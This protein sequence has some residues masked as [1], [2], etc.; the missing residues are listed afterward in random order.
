[1]WF[2][3]MKSLVPEHIQKLTP[4]PP[5]KP[6]SELERE[7]GVT[8]AIKLA[9]NENALGPSPRATAA[10]AGAM[11]DINRYPD[12]GAF[13]LKRRLAEHLGVDHGQLLVG[14]G[15]NEII[16][17]LIRTFGSGGAEIVT[18]ECTFVIYRLVSSAAGARFV[19]VPMANHRFDLDAI[20]E[21]VSADTRM[22]FLCNPNNPT[23]TIFSQAEL[24][25]FLARVGPDPIVVLDEAYIEYVSPDARIDALA[26]LRDRPRTVVLR[27]FSKAYGLAGVRVGYGVATEDLVNYVNRVRQPFNVNHLAQVAATAALGDAEHLA[28]VVAMAEEGKRHIA[29]EVEAMGC[30]PV[31]SATNFVLFDTHREAAPIYQTLLRRGVIIRPMTAYGL[32]THLRV[33]AGL[34][35]DRQRFLDELKV[36]LGA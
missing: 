10:M 7:L 13:Y 28:R 4:Y 19:E 8:R 12:G 22:V 36:A 34:P 30:T 3:A 6:L 21:R 33:D 5:G 18:S 23:G 32:P 27:T 15:S 25:R 17:L 24:D 9:S 29:V 2:C 11:C 35:E 31:P 20:A 26:V 16:E 1:M 14:N